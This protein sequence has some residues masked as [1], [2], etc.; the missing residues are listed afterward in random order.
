MRCCYA[1][2]RPRMLLRENEAER[3]TEMESIV[4]RKAPEFELKGVEEG[5]F[6][7]FKLS[8]YEGKWLIL[9]FYP[10]DF[11]FVCPTEILAF[12]DRLDEF[13]KLGAS[14]LGCSTDSVY[15]HLAWT[16]KPQEEG[17][18]QGLKYPLLEDTKKELATDYGTLAPDGAVALRGLFII[19]P[20]GVVQHAT[21]NNLGVGRSVDETLR[22]LQGFQFVQ[23]H[24]EVCP[25]D[26]RPGEKTMKPDPDSFTEY[27]KS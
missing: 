17:G 21:I 18:I 4:G 15:S 5:A 24:G 14:I 22:L 1:N 3:G 10:L 7:T 19:D 8:D 9:F 23:E 13:E 6:K 11:T 12:S 2:L 26:W 25:A 20:D 27:F 16:E